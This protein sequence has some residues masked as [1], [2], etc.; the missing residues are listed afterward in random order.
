[1]TKEHK[2]V[3]IALVMPFQ[4]QVAVFDSFKSWRKYYK[5]IGSPI[6]PKW[7]DGAAALAS[8]HRGSN[9]KYWY[10]IIVPED[11]NLGTIVHECSHMVDYIC[12]DSGVPINM[13][14]TEIRAYMLGV[15]FLDVCEILRRP[16]DAS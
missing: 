14:N 9:G 11:G 7:A 8:T 5:K 1:M 12:D 2:P 15:L 6:N 10:S 4:T 3:G 13:E 16:V